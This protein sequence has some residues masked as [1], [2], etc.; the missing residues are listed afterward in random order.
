M[1]Q[2]ILYLQK[3]DVLKTKR[4]I[5]AFKAIDRADFVPT[6]YKFLAYKDEALPIG[7]EQTISQPTVVAFMLELLEPQPGER[8]LDVGSGSGWTTALLASI[9]GAKGK[10]YGVE[11]VLELVTFG[12][13]NIAKYNFRSVEIT[14]AGKT[15]GLPLKAPFDKILVGA[16]GSSVPQSLIDQLKIGGVM[17]IPI[18]EAIWKVH[19]KS[20]SETDI[21]KFEGFLFVPLIN[22]T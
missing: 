5:D 2:L 17:V 3:I 7:Y 1:E 11:I 21:E 20:E 14:Q 4:I 15:F 22:N 12:Q 9:V 13:K 8:I 18:N 6:K 16:T 10:V 19:K